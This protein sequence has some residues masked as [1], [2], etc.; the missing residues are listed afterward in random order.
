MIEKLKKKNRF[1][2]AEVGSVH[3]GSFGNAM[4]LI[5]LAASSGATSS[6]HYSSWLLSWD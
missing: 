6:L 2:I 5:S 1:I 4:K 3:D